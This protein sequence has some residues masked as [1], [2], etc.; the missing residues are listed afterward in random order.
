MSYN[1]VQCILGYLKLDYPTPRLSE[2]KHNIEHTLNIEEK[3]DICKLIATDTFR[4]M[5]VDDLI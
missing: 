3:L 5:K 1:S 4:D 2:H